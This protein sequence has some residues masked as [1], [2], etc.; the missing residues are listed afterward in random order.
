MIGHPSCNQG[1]VL[2][3]VGEQAVDVLTDRGLYERF[4]HEFR[5][6]PFDRRDVKRTAVRVVRAALANPYWLMRGGLFLLRK[7]WAV[8]RQLIRRERTGK[9]TFFIH[10]FMDSTALDPE[11]IRNCSFMVMTDDGPISMC[12]HNARRDEFILKPVPLAR[13]TASRAAW[14]PLTG[15]IEESRD[16]LGT[17]PPSADAAF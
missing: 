3:T 12:E 11:R 10:N 8:R 6:V 17:L 7:L 1:A 4:L 5:H 16:P 9:M 14:N 2:A 13:R 15:R